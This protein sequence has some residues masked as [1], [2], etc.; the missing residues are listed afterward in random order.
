MYLYRMVTKN[1][2]VEC[3]VSSFCGESKIKKWLKTSPFLVIFGKIGSYLFLC[4]AFNSVA[5]NFCQ[6]TSLLSSYK[7][8]WFSGYIFGCTALF[9]RVPTRH[10]HILC[11]I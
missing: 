11:R 4:M 1:C 5:L 2:H 3:L 9:H 7:N 10:S 8:C 6:L